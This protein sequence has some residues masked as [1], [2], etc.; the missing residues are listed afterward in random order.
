MRPVFLINLAKAVSRNLKTGPIFTIWGG[1]I[2][3]TIISDIYAQNRV[4]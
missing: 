4:L 3:G 2:S 1:L